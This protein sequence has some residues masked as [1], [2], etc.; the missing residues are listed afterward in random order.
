MN[1]QD[2]SYSPEWTVSEQGTNFICSLIDLLMSFHREPKC[3]KDLS[4]QVEKLMRRAWISCGGEALN[5][6]VQK[7][8]GKAV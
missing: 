5:K 7:K 4:K 2:D 3:F 8:F 6:I 1:L